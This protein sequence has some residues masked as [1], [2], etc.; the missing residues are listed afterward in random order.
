MGDVETARA[1]GEQAEAAGGRGVTVRSDQGAARLAEA[2]QVDLVTD[3]V[4]GAGQIETVFPGDARQ[5]SVIVRVFETDLH[6]VVVDVADGKL[7]P[8][9]GAAHGLE[10]EVGHRPGGVL[11]QGLVD[12][13]GDFLSGLEAA[14]GQMGFQDL[15]CERCGHA[16]VT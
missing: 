3:T 12:P 7:R 15:L 5:I 16:M 14:E 1:D 6:G 13:D 10:L 4:S 2:L 11:R 8:N 9:A